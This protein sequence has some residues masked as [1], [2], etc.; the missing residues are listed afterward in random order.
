VIKQTSIKLQL[1]KMAS[2][3]IIHKCIKTTTITTACRTS[4]MPTVIK[5]I[6]TGVTPD[7]AE[8]TKQNLWNK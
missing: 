3:N 4:I 8:F 1:Q 7:S 6:F 5:R 2:K